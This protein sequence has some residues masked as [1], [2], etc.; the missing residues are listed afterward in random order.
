ML[1]RKVKKVGRRQKEIVCL[2]E[3]EYTASMLG[4]NQVNQR[5]ILFEQERL[6]RDDGWGR[7]WAERSA[8][9]FS[10]GD[11]TCS[12]K[13]QMLT[14]H[15][16]HHKTHPKLPFFPF[17]FYCCLQKK[18]SVVLE[19]QQLLMKEI[20]FCCDKWWL[21]PGVCLAINDSWMFWIKMNLSE[22]IMQLN[23]MHHS[24]LTPLDGNL[25]CWP[26]LSTHLVGLVPA[27]AWCLISSVG[28]GWMVITAP[29]VVRAGGGWSCVLLYASGCVTWTCSFK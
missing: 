17:F 6:K 16:A 18:D 15:S 29:A 8:M 10:R 5:S 27:Y 2:V 28:N 4:E 22:N 3:T 23:L 24:F 26:R 13:N 9:H 11:A 7:R 1:E 21:Q 14:K 12:T 25:F 20:L 19:G